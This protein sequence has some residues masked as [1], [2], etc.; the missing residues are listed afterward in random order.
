MAPKLVASDLDGTLLTSEGTFDERTVRAIAAA[1][2]AGTTVVF[3]TA[4]PPRWMAPL[5]E[6]AGHRGVAICANG[7]VLW[8]LHTD[9]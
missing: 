6:A 2:A 9:R 5:A 1:E 7:A 8:D 3:C 4:R